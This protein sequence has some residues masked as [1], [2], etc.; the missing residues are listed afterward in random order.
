MSETRTKILSIA[1]QAW[2]RI[3]KDRLSPT[4]EVF[5]LWY[6]YFGKTN[7][8][9]VKNIDRM[10]AQGPLN[11]EQCTELHHRYLSETR[12]TERIL[13]AGDQVSQ[14]IQGLTEKVDTVNDVSQGFTDALAKAQKK[15]GSGAD[16]AT[17]DAVV[18]A[19]HSETTAVI[20]KNKSLA[21]DMRALTQHMTELKVELDSARREALTDGLTGL[22]NRKAF[23]I[24]VERQIAEARKE[25]QPLSL[26]M[27]DIDHFKRFNDNFGHQVGDQVLRL[28]ARTLKDGVKGRDFAARYGGEE[29]AILLPHT[30][31]PAA[32]ALANQLIQAVA[33]KDIVNKT[34]GDSLGRITMSIGVS[35][36]GSKEVAESLI[37][38]ADAALYTA[39]H[40]GRN[41]MA[42]APSIDKGGLAR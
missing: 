38:R 11:D 32:S 17:I 41:Q 30:A 18:S 22:A 14:A 1:Q 26:L 25:K 34:T 2:D 8:D 5:A 10:L 40:N 21:A 42:T 6:A 35:E 24:E 19:L 9:I 20:D 23:D 3:L 15:L 4:P 7:A 13:Q 37:T 28:V 12:Q 33:V 39:K 31:M 16:K 29:F 36:L 27:L